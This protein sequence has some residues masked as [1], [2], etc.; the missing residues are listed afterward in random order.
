M[1]REGP[2]NP[3]NTRGSR[4]TSDSANNRTGPPPPRGGRINV[5]DNALLAQFAAAATEGVEGYP[6]NMMMHDAYPSLGP[7]PGFYGNFLP[8]STM[9]TP[10]LPPLGTLDFP[11][12]SPP[13]YQPQAGPSHY[14]SNPATSRTSA[15]PFHDTPFPPTAP[16]TTNRWGQQIQ[17]ATSSHTASSPEVEQTEAERNDIADEKRRRNTAASG[18]ARFRIKKKNKTVTLERSVSNLTGRAEE[19]EREAADLRRENGWLKEIVMLKGS[20]FAASNLAHGQGSSQAATLAGRA[21]EREATEGLP[22]DDSSDEEEKVP[23]KNK[24]KARARSRKP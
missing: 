18:E 2:P 20:R 16:V 10:Q 8:H 3:R 4:S 21:G 15:Q 23:E 22:S 12:H 11:W 19:L 7:A 5:Q 17:P 1:D 14:A 24:G 9:P 6:S 13:Q